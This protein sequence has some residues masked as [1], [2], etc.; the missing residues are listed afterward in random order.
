MT[1]VQIIIRDKRMPRTAPE[2]CII[3]SDLVV[4]I[5]LALRAAISWS[6]NTIF[7]IGALPMIE[8]IKLN[9]DTRH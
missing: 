9:T 2:L 1:L 5:T 7:K 3:A 8:I 4:A 6:V